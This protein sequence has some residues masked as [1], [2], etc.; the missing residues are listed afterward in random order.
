MIHRLA[1]PDGITYPERWISRVEHP[2][3]PPRPTLWPTPP[4][5]PRP[6]PLP[7]SQIQLNPFLVHRVTGKSPIKF[8]MRSRSQDNVEMGD[9]CPR[10]GDESRTPAFVLMHPRGPNGAQPATFPGVAEMRIVALAGEPLA[11]FPWPFTVHARDGLPVTV[12]D[13]LFSL[14]INF[15]QFMT[16]DEVAEFNERRRETIRIAYDRRLREKRFREDGE[17]LRRID[18]LGDRIMFRGLEPAPGGEGW[19]M[20]VGPLS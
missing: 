17:G 2:S 20:F 1:G 10:E 5:S 12:Q 13:V 18:F 8:D 6:P 16:A 9:E 15:A 7:S 19:M 4:P 11:H 14:L 3:L